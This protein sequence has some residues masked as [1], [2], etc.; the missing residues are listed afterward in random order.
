[1]K[2]ILYKSE[3][4]A[5]LDEL[6]A[7][8]EDDNPLNQWEVEERDSIR[9]LLSQMERDGVEDLI[10]ED[11]FEDHARQTAEGIGAIDDDTSWPCNCIDWERAADEL[12]VDYTAVE[13]NGDTYYYR[14]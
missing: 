3:L 7:E 4:Q 11:Y 8:D 14:A 12:R 6:E 1:M 13:F 2:D 9:E 5:R 10:S